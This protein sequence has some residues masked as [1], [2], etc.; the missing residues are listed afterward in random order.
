[1]ISHHPNIEIL[2]QFVEGNTSVSISVI[3]SA[4][5]EMCPE[6]QKR[7]D[8][9]TE[10][11]A[12]EAFGVD[13][14]STLDV[15]DSKAELG[16]MTVAPLD[17]GDLDDGISLA[18][19]DSMTSEQPEQSSRQLTTVTEIDVD[20]ERV[21]LPR[22]L[23][24]VLVKEWKGFGKISR[25]RLKLDDGAR[26]TSLLH[27]AKGG[28]IP[29]HTHRGFEITLLLQG[30]F[31][32]EFGHYSAGDFIW[33]NTTHTHTPVTH[34]GCVCLTVS[35]DALQFTQGVSQMMNPIGKLIY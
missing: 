4:H 31:D 25:A 28:H 9:I 22:S 14:M 5:V 30:S 24:S 15:G 29:S 20:G 12:M 27:I 35:D 1:M 16:S 26:R 8:D 34:D 13:D 6:C 17:D 23:K 19:I 18:L 33:L 2:K 7:V 10:A 3:V 21:S 11:A 32:D